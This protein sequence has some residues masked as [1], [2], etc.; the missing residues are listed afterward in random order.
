MPPLN[1]A[2][3]FRSEGGYFYEQYRVVFEG[4]L[5]HDAALGTVF[6]PGRRV[7]R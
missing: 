7:Q 2:A 1:T 3:Y 5:R 6:A 4:A